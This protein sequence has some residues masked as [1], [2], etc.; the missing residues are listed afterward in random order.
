MVLVSVISFSLLDGEG[1]GSAGAGI[2]GDTTGLNGDS[3]GPVLS[4]L[5]GD[6]FSFSFFH[7]LQ[8]ITR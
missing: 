6:D 5:C 4:P 8:R 7:H 1:K 3:V 2:G